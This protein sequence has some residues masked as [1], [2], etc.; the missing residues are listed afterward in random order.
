MADKYVNIDIAYDGGGPHVGTSIDPYDYS[1]FLA[2]LN[3]GS[4]TYNID[5]LR[6]VNDLIGTASG[7]TLKG[8]NGPWRL[9]NTGYH[10]NFLGNVSDAILKTSGYN[11]VFSG[12]VTNCVVISTFGVHVG[13]ELKGCSFYGN[14]FTMTA[15]GNIVRDCIILSQDTVCGG[16]VVFYNCVFGD[17][18]KGL[19]YNKCQF[20]WAEIP[21]PAWDDSRSAFG[22]AVLSAGILSHPPSGDEGEPNPGNPPYTGY[23]T[24]L[25]GST[26]TGI[27]AMDFSV[28]VNQD[29]GDI[30]GGSLIFENDTTGPYTGPY[31]WKFGETEFS[32]LETP[33]SI[34][35][36]FSYLDQMVEDQLPTTLLVNGGA[37][38]VTKNITI[39]WEIVPTTA[40]PTTAEPTTAE[41]TTA[42]PTTVAPTTVAPTT[43]TAE[44]TTTTAEP[45]LPPE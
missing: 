17:G 21:I 40:E 5:G 6:T 19:T 32:T 38:Q 43:T 45:T 3:T 16:N 10:M 44:P 36:I 27:G 15:E 42:E 24:G 26:R 7:E 4:D 13:A 18:N 23:E 34:P 41:P 14:F 1:E 9:Y 35:N 31:S 8:W 33:E 22:S 37:H 11:A 2:L 20:N 28:T 29:T 12:V 25:W 39:V 30:V